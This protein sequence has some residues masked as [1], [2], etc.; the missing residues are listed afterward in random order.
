M[1]D[2]Q[3]TFIVIS[4]GFAIN[5]E[6]STCLPLQQ[7]LIKAINKNFPSIKI[8]IVAFQYPLI[9]SEYEWYGNKVISFG[10]RTRGKLHTLLLW[11]KV[12]LRLKKLNK[13][14]NVKGLLSFWAGECALIGNRFGKYHN[15]KH[16]CWILGQDAKKENH[17]IKRMKPDPEELIALSD[18]IASE[19]YKNHG[20]LPAHI[21]TPGIEPSQF[22]HDNPERNI[23]VLGVG[24]LI[25]LKQYEVFIRII[26]VL[27]EKF[28]SIHAV[29]SGKG[30][31]EENLKE[32]IKLYKLENNIALIGEIPYTEV[33]AIMQRTKIF[34]HP[35]TYEG[36]GVVCIEAL[37]AGAHVISFSKPMNIEIEQWHIVDN[38]TEMLARAIEILKNSHIEYRS[39]LFSSMDDCAKKMVKL[40]GD[41]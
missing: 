16:R 39:V 19:F 11:S 35:S 27:K 17:H 26:L 14:N 6:D 40:F 23:D 37:Y 31:E 2:M 36:F 10:S 22:R 21:I 33:L 41:L 12:W 24:S 29:I 13:E 7:N 5:E 3:P 9:R 32:Q 1:K 38:E 28:P 25:S 20:I 15:I 30:P 8:I 34:L 18:F 4:P